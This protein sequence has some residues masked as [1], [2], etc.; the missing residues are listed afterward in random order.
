MILLIALA[1][2]NRVIKNAFISAGIYIVISVIFHFLFAANLQISYIGLLLNFILSIVY[3]WLLTRYEDTLITWI[4]IL[5][6]G[7]FIVNFV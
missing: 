2:L 3:F 6:V 7:A 1:C 4:L 5:I